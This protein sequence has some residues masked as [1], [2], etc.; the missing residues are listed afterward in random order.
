M[1][2]YNHKKSGLFVDGQGRLV[3]T[4]S[5]TISIEIEGIFYNLLLNR[6]EYIF[7]LNDFNALNI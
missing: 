7:R 4:F 3:Y 1:E 5:Q 2:K 6:Y